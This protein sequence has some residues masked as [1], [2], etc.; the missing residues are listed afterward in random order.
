[1]FVLHGYLNLDISFGDKTIETRVYIK[2]DA[3]NE[4]LLSEGVCRQLGIISY[5]PDVKVKGSPQPKVN[6]EE[7]SATIPTIRVHLLQSVRVPAGCS[8]IVPVQLKGGSLTCKPMRMERDPA[9]EESIGLR[10]EDALLQP[11]EEGIAHLKL[12]N[13]SGFTSILRE[14]TIVGEA[15]EATVVP[16]SQ[17]REDS[18][19]KCAVPDVKRV[20]TISDN[21]RRGELLKVLEE[22]DL[23][24]PEKSSYVTSW[25]RTI[26]H[27]ALRKENHGET[28]LIQM[29]I[30]TGDT[31]PRKQPVR[32]MPLQLG[33]I[34]QDC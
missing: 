16:P 14:G 2:M 30:D 22:P 7:Q 19:T 28:D 18:V 29:E 5:H 34:S 20:S 1:M 32:R 4:L 6:G 9:V 10:L 31:A 3:H 24:E 8:T 27:S 21:E 17:K 25:E 11:S 26:L 13:S 33:V 23:P 12:F 15:V